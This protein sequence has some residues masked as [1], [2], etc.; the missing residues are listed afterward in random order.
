MAGPSTKQ[1]L[2]VWFINPTIEYLSGGATKQELDCHFGDNVTLTRS[3]SITGAGRI[4][5]GA[6]CSIAAGEN[7]SKVIGPIFVY[8]NSLSKF[9]TPSEADLET[10]T[11]TAGNPHRSAAWKENATALWQDAL[12]Q[13]KVE[14][15]QWPYD[16]VN[17]VD[18]PHKDERGTLTGTARAR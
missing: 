15:A 16:W 5:G 14:T 4:S 10:L 6:Q 1:H 17:G 18:Y 12:R 3:S 2:G 11:N 13:A 7:W 9:K 8:V